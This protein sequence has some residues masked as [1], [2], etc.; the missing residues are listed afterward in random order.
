MKKIT[1]HS[2]GTGSGTVVLDEDGRQIADVS[3]IVLDI[4]AGDIARATLEVVTPMSN[5]N[6]SVEHVVFVC[7][8]CGDSN[9]H[10]C[11]PTLGGATSH[12]RRCSSKYRTLYPDQ[13][14]SCVREDGHDKLHFDGER[15][16]E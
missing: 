15:A 11:G 10:H 1:V 6:A 14:F 3:N 2:D 8:L 16:W 7:P 5:V 9:D 12:V 4:A 13:E